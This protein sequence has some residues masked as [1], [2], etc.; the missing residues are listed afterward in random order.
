MVPTVSVRRAAG[1]GDHAPATG[2]G[3]ERR[4]HL[5][6]MRFL[7][8]RALDVSADLGLR[9]CGGDGDR[10]W[11]GAA[12][13]HLAMRRR[14]LAGPAVALSALALL[15]APLD[16]A[17]QEP[18]PAGGAGHAPHVNPVPGLGSATSAPAARP[19]APSGGVPPTTR[20][21]GTTLEAQQR[22]DGSQ[23]A[24][25]WLVGSGIAAALAVGLGGWALKRRTE[26]PT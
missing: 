8:D 26:R 16:A 6:V 11:A 24:T 18:A 5:G 12:C 1:A 4:R 20:R 2:A 17:G 10:N 23:D 13:D 7:L 9:P 21:D 22:D 14:L 25:P 3:L 15:L 19:P